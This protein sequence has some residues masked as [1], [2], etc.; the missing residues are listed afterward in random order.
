MVPGPDETPY[1]PNA[2]IDVRYAFLPNTLG[3]LW[4]V[5]LT[6]NASPEGHVRFQTNRRDSRAQLGALWR[7]IT[8]D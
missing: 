3:A 6:P 5:V 7:M 4:S 1:D 2:V 8:A